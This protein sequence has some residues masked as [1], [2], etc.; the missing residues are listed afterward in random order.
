MADYLLVH[1]RLKF[2]LMRPVLATS[3]RRKSFRDCAPYL[4]AWRDAA[5]QYAHSYHID[6]QEILLLSVEPK[7]RFASALWRT[8]VGELL[9]VTADEMPELPGHLESLARLLP[10]SLAVQTLEGCG[11]LLFGLATYRPGRSRFNSIEDNRGLLDELRA[12][13]SSKWSAEML[14]SGEMDRED[15]SEELLFAREWFA[16][17][18]D[19]YERVVR[20]DRVIVFETIHG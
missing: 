11:D 5:H 13:D 7:T 16:V 17:L 6:P 10:E 18:L 4:D 15:A 12:I 19:L 14:L 1:D 8:L 20:D 2:E 3:W 9:V